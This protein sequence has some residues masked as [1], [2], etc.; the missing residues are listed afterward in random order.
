MADDATRHAAADSPEYLEKYPATRTEQ[1]WEPPMEGVGLG[2]A[3]DTDV[4]IPMRDG[5][6]LAANVYRPVEPGEKRGQIA[7]EHPVILQFTGWGKDLYWGDAEEQ[8]GTAWPGKG[9]GYGPSSPPVAETCTFEAEDPHFWVPQGYVLVVV[10]GRGFGRSP[11]QFTGYDAWGRD[12]HD[13]VEWAGEQAWSSGK[14]GMSGVSILSIMQYHAAALDPDHLEAICPWQATPEDLHDHGGIAPVVEPNPP[15]QFPIPREPAWDAPAETNPPEIPGD[16]EDEVFESI[17]HP[18]L[19][20]GSWSSHGFFSRGDFRAFRKLSSEHKWLYNHGREKWATFYEDEAQAF[21]KQFFDHFLRG[22]DDRILDQPPVRFEVRDSLRNWF[23]RSAD[24]FPL[25][26]TDYR[27]LYLDAADGRL[28]ETA[29][30]HEATVGYDATAN[31]PASFAYT[32]DE[33]TSLVGYQSLRL[34]VT[35]EDAEDA[36]LYVTVRKFDRDGEQV[37]F[38]G[39][40]AP[41]AQPA[42]LGFLRLSHRRLDEAASTPWNPYLDE[43]ADPEPVTPGEP[44][45]CHV[46]IRAS[47][48]FFRSGETLRVDVS[49]TFLGEDD[50]EVTYPARR[51]GETA[52]KLDSVNEGRH[53]IHTG[54][55]YDS[56]L[57]VPEVPLG[58]EH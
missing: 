57:L 16:P 2:I 47:G 36:D 43:S 28:T 35:P 56:R 51:R 32:F 24:D 17:T 25:P 31:D 8:F 53:T 41:L 1:T 49:G 34:W 38:H 52:L 44:V 33:P 50:F 29:P 39:Y 58:P 3:K 27:E 46:P 6:E 22:T 14:V 11:G 13:A 45:V 37:R 30:D 48:T 42:A 21:R 26:D 9:V 23:V 55:E 40:I 7:D 5:L 54:G 15:D 18:A 20:C 19:I 10:D 4:P 12:A